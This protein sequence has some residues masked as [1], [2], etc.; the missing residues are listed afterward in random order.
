M[1][2]D[3]AGPSEKTKSDHVWSPLTGAR[4]RMASRM[5]AARAVVRAT[6]TDVAD[7]SVWFDPEADVLFRLARAMTRGVAAS[8]GLNAWYDAARIALSRR[9]ALDLGLAVD[10]EVGLYVPVV[11]DVGSL[12]AA[13]FRAEADRL[14]AAAH[15]RALAPADTRD[16]TLTLSSFGTL[17]GRFAELVVTPPQVA[18]LGAGRVF[19]SYERSGERFHLPLSLSFDH[20]A[21]TGGDA[22]RF[23]ATVIED[24][25]QAD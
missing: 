19:P 20:R 15:A 14:V 7:V 3:V 2:A 5:D 22:A 9:A 6:L 25:A 4:R 17:G 11:R 21:A 1:R 24:L 13:A 16:A 23:L 12:N 10:T 8:P 18:I